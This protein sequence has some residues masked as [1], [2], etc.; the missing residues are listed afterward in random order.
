MTF[1]PV[2]FQTFVISFRDTCIIPRTL[3]PRTFIPF[4]IIPNPT[5]VGLVFKI[6][7]ITLCDRNRVSIFI[8]NNFKQYVIRMRYT[9]FRIL[10]SEHTFYVIPFPCYET[11][12]HNHTKHHS[13]QKWVGVP[14]ETSCASVVVTVSFEDVVIWINIYYGRLYPLA[15]D[16]TCMTTH[17]CLY[18]FVFLISTMSHNI[19]INKFLSI[20]HFV[21][22]FMINRLPSHLFLFVHLF[23]CLLLSS[24]SL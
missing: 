19:S 23:L 24:L 8:L 4:L 3:P 15:N 9:I 16:I 2:F 7:I 21:I 20:L 17:I 5:N 11:N 10:Y 18:S 6:K 12:V 1:P 14:Q 13:V 22:N